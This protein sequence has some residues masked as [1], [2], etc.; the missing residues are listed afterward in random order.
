M[1]TSRIL[2]LMGIVLMALALTAQVDAIDRTNHKAAKKAV[3]LTV[4]KPIIEFMAKAYADQ[5]DAK[6]I[7]RM[8][9]MLGQIDHITVTF[10]DADASD[11]VL[12]FKTLDEHG[13][14]DW[15]FSEGYLTSDPEAEPAPSAIESWMLDP[16]YL[17]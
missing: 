14:E 1:K 8:Q 2:K 10:R 3:T 15:M 9:K 16:S 7:I 4:D 12:K 11:Y 13:L 5:I 17:E 6:D